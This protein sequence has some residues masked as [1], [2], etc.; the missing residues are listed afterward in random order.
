M[1][2]I[3]NATLD[4]E[5][6][7]SRFPV[8]SKRSCDL[9]PTALVLRGVSQCKT[10]ALCL[11]T[12]S[13]FDEAKGNIMSACQRPCGH[14][15]IRPCEAPVED[16]GAA[17]R[18]CHFGAIERFGVDPLVEAGLEAFGPLTLVDLPSGCSV[19]QLVTN[20]VG[21]YTR[22]AHPVCQRPGQRALARSDLPAD[23]DDEWRS[24]AAS[25]TRKGNRYKTSSR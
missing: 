7:I 3:D 4:F 16:D 6:L 23:G 22:D 21:D 9:L 8:G 10:L 11:V 15:V 25:I 1:V 12:D 2:T 14:A 19:Q 17:R 13:Q 20:A 24:F 18:Q 5:K